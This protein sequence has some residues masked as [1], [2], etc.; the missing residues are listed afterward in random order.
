MMNRLLRSP[1]A[2]RFFDGSRSLWVAV[3]VVALFASNQ[4]AADDLSNY[5]RIE[6]GARVSLEIPR[7]WKISDLDERREIAVAGEAMMESALPDEP[8]FV[9]AL[10]A[11]SPPPVGGI[12]RVSYIPTEEPEYWLDQAGLAAAVRDDRAGSIQVLNEAFGQEMSLLAESMKNLGIEL[13][14]HGPAG[15]EKINGTNAMTYTYRRTSTSGQDSAFRV[16]QYHI[17]LGAEKVLM[18]LS[19]RES[20]ALIYGAILDKVKSSLEIR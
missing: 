8:A 14:S 20:D 2:R 18:T 12:I 10:S 5:H 17:P 4:A 9:S 1:D 7:H 16:T 6:V 3:V 15:I 19:Y 13:L 11:Q